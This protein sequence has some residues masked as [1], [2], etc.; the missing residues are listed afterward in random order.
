MHGLFA[1]LEF[2]FLFIWMESLL[3]EKKETSRK[4]HTCQKNG[5]FSGLKM[6]KNGIR[7]DFR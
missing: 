5:G 2:E 7:E 1:F 6:R 3:A 4:N